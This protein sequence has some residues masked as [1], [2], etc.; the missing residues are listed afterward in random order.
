MITKLFDGLEVFLGV[1]MTSSNSSKLQMARDAIY[2]AHKLEVAVCNR[3]AFFCV[4]FGSSGAQSSVQPVSL[5]S[6]V[7]VQMSAR[8]SV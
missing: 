7:A 3:W 4:G 1:G 8:P 5:S 6:E 2:I